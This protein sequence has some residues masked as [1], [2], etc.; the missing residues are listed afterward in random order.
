MSR[1]F[2]PQRYAAVYVIKIG[3]G[4]VVLWFGL[5]AAGIDDPVWALISLV[6]V[7]EP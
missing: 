1:W 5:G 4:C 6:F 2:A 3:C 7:V